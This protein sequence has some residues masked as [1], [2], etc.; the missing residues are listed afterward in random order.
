MKLARPSSVYRRICFFLLAGNIFASCRPQNVSNRYGNTERIE[1]GTYR[2]QPMTSSPLLTDLEPEYRLV[3]L[4]EEAGYLVSTDT[5]LSYVI[6]A[7]GKITAV[8]HSDTKVKEHTRV[9][10][11]SD[12]AVWLVGKTELKY[13]EDSKDSAALPLAGDKVR[14]LWFSAKQLLLW[15]DYQRRKDGGTE[16]GVQLYT[17]D[18]SGRVKGTTK[19]SAKEIASSVATFAGAEEFIAGGVSKQDFWLWTRASGLLVFHEK[20]DNEYQVEDRA[21]ISLPRID[22]VVKD[23]GFTLRT[24]KDDIAPPEYVLGIAAAGGNRGALY[25][26]AAR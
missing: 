15:G 7:S 24:G 26:G 6:D 8:D 1:L 2:L 9:L 12:R 19:I 11:A 5:G 16:R 25:I 18:E 10:A 17:L 22:K 3:S 4:Q 23:I 21:I 14:V 20:G 13:S